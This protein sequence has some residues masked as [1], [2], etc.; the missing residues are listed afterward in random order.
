V[1]RSDIS[2]LHRFRDVTTFPVYRWLSV[3]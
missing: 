2:V 3:T 1:I